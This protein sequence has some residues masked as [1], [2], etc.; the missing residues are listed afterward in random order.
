MS[1]TRSLMLYWEVLGDGRCL[2]LALLL[3]AFW[4][5]GWHNFFSGKGIFDSILAYL[6]GIFNHTE[7]PFGC[8]YQIITIRAYLRCVTLTAKWIACSVIRP[9]VPSHLS[10]GSSVPGQLSVGIQRCT[11][12]PRFRDNNGLHTSL[13]YAIGCCVDRK[14]RKSRVKVIQEPQ[15][16]SNSESKDGLL[17][18]RQDFAWSSKRSFQGML[19]DLDG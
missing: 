3:T 2:P 11:L 13:T 5:T 8:Q 18:A 10:P 19:I 7:R 17:R 16:K 9:Q 4:R 1:C 6:A 14:E 15:G 12:K